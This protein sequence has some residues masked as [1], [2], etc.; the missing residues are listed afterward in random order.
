MKKFQH[1]ASMRTVHSIKNIILILPLIENAE[2][3]VRG[4]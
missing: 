2:F 3:P 1:K 4:F